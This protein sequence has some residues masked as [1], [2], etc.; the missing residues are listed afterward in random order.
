MFSFFLI[1]DAKFCSFQDLAFLHTPIYFLK[2]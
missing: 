2:P 1:L